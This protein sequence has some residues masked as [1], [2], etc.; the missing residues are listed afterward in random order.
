MARHKLTRCEQLK[1]LRKCLRSKKTPRWLKPSIRR[2]L[3]KL[4]RQ[5]QRESK[6]K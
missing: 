5:V 1:G 3:Q 4:Q 2:Y 6:P